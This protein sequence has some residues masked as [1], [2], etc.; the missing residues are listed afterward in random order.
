MQRLKISRRWSMQ[1]IVLFFFAFSCCDE[2][3]KEIVP[4]IRVGKYFFG[5]TTSEQI[6]Q[7]PEDKDKL[8]NEGIMF[9]FKDNKL[10]SIVLSNKAYRTKENIGVGSTQETVINAFGQ[11]Y[12]M[13]EISKG[14]EVWRIEDSLAY[15]NM[16]FY[17]N[18]DGIVTYILLVS[19]TPK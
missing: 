1:Y 3:S 7:E 9:T 10:D 5:K 19:D 15:D 17:C 8:M 13:G 12:G 14:E 2:S 16:I 4:G 6:F 18:D 11:P